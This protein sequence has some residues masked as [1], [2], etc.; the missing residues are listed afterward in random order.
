[1]TRRRDGAASDV[2]EVSTM[3]TGPKAANTGERPLDEATKKRQDQAEIDKI[4]M[5]MAQKGEGE[6]DVDEEVNPEDTMFT[7]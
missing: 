7:K 5:E 2:A 1:M 6:I 4:A 3:A